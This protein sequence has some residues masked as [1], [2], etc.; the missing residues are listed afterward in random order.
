M[1]LAT[2]EQ[3]ERE[4]LGRLSNYDGDS[5]EG[6]NYEG[7]SYDG[8]DDSFVDF[9]GD[10]FNGLARSFANEI[11]ASRAYIFTITNALATSEEYL[12]NSGY[13]GILGAGT[14]QVYEGTFPAV[15]GNA[16]SCQ[17]KP[18]IYNDFWA[19]SLFNPTRVIGFK[20]SSNNTDNHEMVLEVQPLSPYKKLGA[21]LIY[22]SAHR[23][24]H[25]FKDNVTTVKEAFDMNNQI[26]IKGSIA[27]NS[28]IT[29][30]FVMG[31]TLNTAAA[32]KRK[33]TK[34]KR[35]SLKKGRPINGFSDGE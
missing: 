27:A 10:G 11:K 6:D 19:F 23:N 24:E 16:L 9:D 2:Q 3:I 30:T 26:Q 21:R 8:F 17:G 12:I 7:E 35:N 20:L 18:S 13:Q 34:A 15:S 28:S 32:L 33:R 14:G 29:F 4:A 25:T 1:N 5:Y 22:V 31:A